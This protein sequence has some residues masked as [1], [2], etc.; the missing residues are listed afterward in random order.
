MSRIHKD[1][2]PYKSSQ[3]YYSATSF[4][5]RHHVRW[6]WVEIDILCTLREEG[7]SFYEIAQILK[8][9]EAA[10]YLRYA[11]ATGRHKD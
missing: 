5:P 10:C 3:E 1:G 9:S 6:D 4:A 8:R 2:T 11:R 7:K